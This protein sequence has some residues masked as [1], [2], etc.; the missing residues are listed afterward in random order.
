MLA[1]EVAMAVE[2]QS[3][4]MKDN[5]EMALGLAPSLSDVSTSEDFVKCL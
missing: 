4:R 1:S 3:L 5:G 2:M